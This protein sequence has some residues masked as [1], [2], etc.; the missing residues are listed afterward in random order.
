MSETHP[1][2][3]LSQIQ[4]AV[5]RLANAQP[6]EQKNA[7]EALAQAI[8]DH[9]GHSC[10]STST[11]ELFSSEL[12]API[13]R[14]SA[15]WLVLSLTKSSKALK[16]GDTE[17]LAAALFDRAFQND[18]YGRINIGPGNQTFEKLRS[19]M[20]HMQSVL[21][22]VDESILVTPHLS[23]LRAFQGEVM[24][25]FNHK[26]A[27]PL[28][29]PLLPRSLT[30][31]TRLTNLFQAI[32]DYAENTD[33]DPINRRDVA[34]D[35]CDEFEKEAREFG[36]V[37]AERIL[38]GLALRLKSAVTTHFDSLEATNSPILTFSP[39]AKKYR[40]A[41]IGHRDRS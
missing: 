18:V 2:K 15:V 5:D 21:A 30:H 16:F 10:D 11:T 28:L 24:R 3:N 6:G 27:Q 38:G 9:F 19:L 17:R 33:A 12:P 1:E 23:Q 8:L 31:K 40:L 35:V 13:Q 20:D 39:V 14:F 7:F 36:T 32:T 4:S 22:K 29:M 34:C 37:D 26:A 41:K 25:V